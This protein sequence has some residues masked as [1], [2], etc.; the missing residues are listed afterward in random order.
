MVP[1][2]SGQWPF[3]YENGKRVDDAHV[4]AKVGVTATKTATWYVMPVVDADHLTFC[5][6]VLNETVSGTRN[7]FKGILSNIVNCGC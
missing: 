2:E 1:V 4:S 3:H 6:G 7:L 5:G